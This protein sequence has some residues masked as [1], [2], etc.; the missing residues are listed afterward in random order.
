MHAGIKPGLHF[1]V[2]GLTAATLLMGWRFSL[3]AG[4]LVVIVMAG[5][6]KIRI[7]EIGLTYCLVVIIP[8]L[9]TYS[10]Y[11]LIQRHLPQNPFVYILVAGFLNAGLT[12]AVH[13][14]TVSS[15]YLWDGIYTTKELWLDYLRF[16]PLM[17]FPEGII[18]GMFL[19]GMVSFNPQ[20]LSTFDEDS[21]FN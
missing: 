3:L 21:Y 16:L 7:A 12:Q 13:A 5:F 17:M 14:L 8:V 1:H 15:V 6:G 4:A 20:W 2:L 9:F 11:L 18:N 19:A 10:L